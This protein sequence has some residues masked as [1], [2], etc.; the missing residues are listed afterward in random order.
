MCISIRYGNTSS[1]KRQVVQFWY[2]YYMYSADIVYRLLDTSMHF[3]L[4]ILKSH[5]TKLWDMR[6]FLFSN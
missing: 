6:S 3:Q 5:T 2:V 1:L 4:E